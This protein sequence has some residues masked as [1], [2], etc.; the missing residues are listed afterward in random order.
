MKKKLITLLLLGFM[1]FN[2]TGCDNNKK[3]QS[4][5]KDNVKEET[6]IEDKEIICKGEE[7]STSQNEVKL[8]Q[9]FVFHFKE[10]KA[11]TFDLVQNIKLTVDNET[12]RKQYDALTEEY[13][14]ETFK[15]M[16]ESA[17]MELKD[18]DVKITEKSN[19]EKEITI[20]FDYKSYLEL[21]AENKEDVNDYLTFD[22]FSKKAIKEIG[23]DM[24]CTYNGEVLNKSEE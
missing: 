7:D 17:N 5:N 11:T 14:K 19:T 9:D 16:F 1:I 10:D 15:S 22:D 18:F 8:K 23:N 24:T 6:K 2:V 20:T 3:E 4:E 13:Y 12:N 21:F